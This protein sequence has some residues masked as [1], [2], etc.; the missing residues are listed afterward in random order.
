MSI[1]LNL[2]TQYY[3]ASREFALVEND[4]SDTAAIEATFMRGLC[5][6]ERRAL[7][8]RVRATSLLKP[9][10]GDDLIWGPT[11]AQAAA[12]TKNRELGLYVTDSSVVQFIYSTLT[13]GYAVGTPYQATLAELIG[14]IAPDEFPAQFVQFRVG[15]DAHEFNAGELSEVF[16]MFHRERLTEAGVVCPSGVDPC[17]GSDLQVWFWN[18]TARATGRF[19][20]ACSGVITSISLTMR[21]KRLP[22]STMDATTAGPLGAV[23]TRRPDRLCHLCPEGELQVWVLLPRCLGRFQACVSRGP[24]ASLRSHRCNPP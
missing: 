6:P 20:K 12:L 9:G 23:K 1:A 13:S 5:W 4:A 10:L 16:E 11:T 18:P 2:Q 3:R 21:R 19:G 17:S 14:S 15:V 8:S 24:L 7:V 22:M